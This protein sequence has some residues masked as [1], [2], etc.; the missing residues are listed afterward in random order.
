MST[1]PVSDQRTLLDIQ[2]LDTTLA[3]LTHRKNAH[4]T[5]A[6]LAE[7]TGRAEDLDRN[8]AQTQVLVSDARRELVKAETDV[9]QVRNRAERDRQRL[10]SGTGS[11]KDLQALSRELESLAKRQS[12]LED[13][14]LEVMERL[15]SAERDL[16]AITEQLQAIRAD[17]ARVEAERDEAFAELDEQ[18]ARTRARREE[19]AGR[20][21][22]D[23]LALYERVRAK[24]GG[25]GAVAL[26]GGATQGIQIP[27]SLTEKSAIEAAPPDQVIRSEDYDYILVRLDD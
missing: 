17:I 6:T 1:A 23:L 24:T 21:D 2:D 9:E 10:E 26:R 5:L 16:A 19:L 12:D 11:P 7:L 20:I 13:V 25:L 4:P 15:E 22:A 14:E 3:K 18:I 8:R 27:L